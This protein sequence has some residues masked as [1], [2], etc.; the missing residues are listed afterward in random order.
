MTQEIFRHPTVLGD[1]LT[2]SIYQRLSDAASP[3]HTGG[4]GRNN[5]ISLAPS[6][7]PAY[8]KNQAD[9]KVED[10][11]TP[12]DAI[13]AA[14]AALDEGDL[15]IL[16]GN[17]SVDMTGTLFS[18]TSLQRCRILKGAAVLCTGSTDETFLFTVDGSTTPIRQIGLIINGSL[19][20]SGAGM[21]ILKV[22]GDVKNIQVEF[23][24]RTEHLNPSI[25]MARPIHFDGD[26]DWGVR[27]VTISGNCKGWMYGVATQD[28]AVVYAEGNVRD[29]RIPSLSIERVS[30]GLGTQLR[31]FLPT[32]VYTWDG[33]SFGTRPNVHDGDLTTTAAWNTTAVRRILICG[34]TPFNSMYMA[35]SSAAAGEGAH[36][37]VETPLVAAP[38]YTLGSSHWYTV[39]ITTDE[40]LSAKKHFQ[41]DGEIELP[42]IEEE[43]WIKA[44]L[45]GVEGYWV[46]IR[47]V[48]SADAAIES[49]STTYRQIILAAIPSDFIGIVNIAGT[50]KA[51]YHW[52]PAHRMSFILN[53]SDIGSHAVNN[54]STSTTVLTSDLQGKGDDDDRYFATSGCITIANIAGTEDTSVLQR[55]ARNNT[56]IVN[57]TG[58]QSSASYEEGDSGAGAPFPERHKVRHCNV[59]FSGRQIGREGGRLRGE[60]N[61]Y[62][63]HVTNPG[64]YRILT[65]SGADRVGVNF[66]SS[67]NMTPP[68]NN[69]LRIVGISTDGEMNWALR[70]DV[71]CNLPNYVESLV[72]IGH[73]IAPYEDNGGALVFLNPKSNVVASDPT[74]DTDST[75]GYSPNSMLINSSDG[76]V[77]IC[78]SAAVG[79]AVWSEIS[80]V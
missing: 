65:D 10:F 36:M 62:N 3:G 24:G 2:R 44:T 57:L 52:R 68:T 7:C 67:N 16:P 33:V 15:D 13:I 9:F 69:T 41:Q 77:F 1:E 20:A 19:L 14:L 22:S 75:E 53:L 39:P 63:F 80:F 12:N 5:T 72:S 64:Q 55:C 61:N 47:F 45:N 43:N 21:G 60:Y 29:V 49:G 27:D 54:N 48:D 42:R 30:Y 23:N 8:L 66:E 38:E 40:T 37:V 26:V 59:I 25:S 71:A 6:N 76:G 56:I 17:I 70:T 11:D 58:A 46:S 35:F 32:T 4:T 34:S 50:T 73:A 74:A 28:R 18:L 78:I 31:S 51:G 79:A